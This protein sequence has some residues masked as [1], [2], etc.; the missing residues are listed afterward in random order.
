VRVSPAPAT[1][2][3]CFK[4][5]DCPPGFCCQPR[6]AAFAGACVAGPGC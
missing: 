3:G 4:T 5:A 1:V 2:I 6:N